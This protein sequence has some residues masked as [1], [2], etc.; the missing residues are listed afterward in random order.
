MKIK[1]IIQQLEK[2]AP[3]SL[4]ESYDNSRLLVGSKDQ[5]VNQLLL[6]LDCTEVVVQEAIDRKCEMI[7]AHHPIVFSGL[8]SLT[9]KNYIERTVIK[10]IKNNIA[11][12]AIHTNLDNV[13]HGVNQ[14]IAEKLGLKNTKILSPKK[15]LLQKLVF[16]CPVKDSEKVRAAIFKAGAGQI[17]DYDACSFNLKGEGTFRAGENTNPH[18]G[19]K[20]K[21]HKEEEHRVEV[22]LPNY[23]EAKVIA[24]LKKAHPYEEVAYD[25]YSLRNS[26]EQVGS[27]MI[28]DLEEEQDF[29]AFLKSLKSKLNTPLIRHTKLHKKKV[30]KVA[31]C[32]G[33]GSFLLNAAKAKG[34]DV[35]ITGDYK[36]HQF[37]DAEDEIVIADVGHYESEQFTPELL[38]EFLMENLPELSTKLVQT[39]TNPISYLT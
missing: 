3:P 25:L 15:E 5:K 33:A 1:D 10:A 6:S 14:K 37:F 2:I 28:G 21:L 36:Y 27:G 31:L 8:K 20:G 18:V 4:Q 23:L 11:I 29:Q 35:F 9:G 13:Y 38:Q 39:N 17:G 34:A 16:F 7:V 12:Y 24:A 32:G 22:V 30:K 19:E 26:W